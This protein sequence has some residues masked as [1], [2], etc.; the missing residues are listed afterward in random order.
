MAITASDLIRRA[1]RILTVIDS[2][3][4][5]DANDARDAL[6]TL[7]A[8]LAEWHEAQIGLPDYALSS[9]TDTLASDAADR[10]AIAYELAL[11]LAPEYGR[12]LSA[13]VA[14]A[15]MASMNR[16]RLRYFQPGTTSFRELPSDNWQFNIVTGDFV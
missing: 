11:R 10:E 8:I 13:E 16:L 5:L 1:L 3:E 7:N 12:S 9:I 14:A 2:Q 6:A 15:G 4:A